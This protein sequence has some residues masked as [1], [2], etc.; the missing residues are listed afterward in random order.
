MDSYRDAPNVNVHQFEDYESYD[1][2]DY[3]YAA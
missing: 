1:D 3:D 2:D